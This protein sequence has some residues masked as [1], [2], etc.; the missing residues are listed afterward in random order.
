MKKRS[1]FLFGAGAAIS[2]KGPFTSEITQLIRES[3]FKT[4]DGTRITEFIYQTLI[5]AGYAENDINFETIINVV[6]ELNIFYSNFDYSKKRQLKS[7]MRCFLN[8]QFTKDIF[9]FSIDG[10]I[11]KHGYM[12][13]IP[14]GVKYNYARPAIN[15]ETPEQHFLQHLLA[16]LLSDIC[17]R[18]SKYAYHTATYSVINFEDEVSINFGN[19]MENLSED[20]TLRLYTTNY[21]RNFKVLMERRN[22]QVFEGFDCGEYI[23]PKEELSANLTRILEDF[24]SHTH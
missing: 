22:I 19:W 1:V 23:D 24:D 7:L 14:K 3:G 10:G 6:E 17:D 13:Q 15:D 8:P 4:N 11:Q 21:D 12:L 18:V 9:N 5:S 16:F 2:W 20:N